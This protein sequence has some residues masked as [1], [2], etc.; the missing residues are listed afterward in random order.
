MIYSLPCIE[1]NC[2]LKLKSKFWNYSWK[3]D[4]DFLYKLNIH[5]LKIEWQ[6]KGS[7]L[8]WF[9]LNAEYSFI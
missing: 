8:V 1:Q 6:N 2:E 4:T 3:I 9:H 5:D 7:I